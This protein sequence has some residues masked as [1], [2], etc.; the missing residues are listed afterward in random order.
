MNG[1]YVLTR[2]LTGQVVL[3]ISSRLSSR[4]NLVYSGSEQVVI[5]ISELLLNL[6]RRAPRVHP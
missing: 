3:C 5:S 1:T 2:V 4:I 6:I